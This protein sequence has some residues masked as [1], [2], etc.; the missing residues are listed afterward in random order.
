MGVEADLLLEIG[1]ENVMKK[2]VEKQAKDAKDDSEDTMANT[3]NVEKQCNDETENVT[4][5]EDGE[6][7]TKHTDDS[8]E[9]RSNTANREKQ[10]N[11]DETSEDLQFCDKLMCQNPANKKCSRCIFIIIDI[12]IFT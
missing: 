6:D 9:I 5:K 10:C 1:E 3:A 12:I 4:T 2:D 7:E 8:E 11:K